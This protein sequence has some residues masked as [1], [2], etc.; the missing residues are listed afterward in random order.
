MMKNIAHKPSN[1]SGNFAEQIIASMPGGV[2]VIDMN[3]TICA[4]NGAMK[5]MLGHH[6]GD[7]GNKINH[8]VNHE[9]TIAGMIPNRLLRESIERGLAQPDYRH[10]LIISVPAAASSVHYL[11][12]TLA[13][14][15]LQ[16][17]DALLLTV[18]DISVSMQTNIQLYESEERFRVAFG[19][20]AVGLAHVTH[21]GRWLRV[22][23]KLQ[24][25]V[26]YSEQELSCLSFHDLTPAEDRPIDE[27]ALRR[28]FKGE[29]QNY[30]RE[31]RYI[32]KGGHVV[33]TNLTLAPM[34]EGQS[35]KSF[36]AVIEDISQRKR[37]EQELLHLSNYDPLTGLSNRVLLLDR[38]SQAITYANRAG[39]FVAVLYIDLDRF[40]NINDSLGHEIGNSVIVEVARRL[41]AS[42]R[43]G[44]TVA[45]LG[46]D[47]FVVVLTDMARESEVALV[48]QKIVDALNLPMVLQEQELSPVGSIGISIYPKD[49][50]DNQTLIKNADA[51]M[52]RAKQAGRSNFQFYAQDMNARSL[53]RLKLES[54]LRHALERGEFVLYY[55]PQM[56]IASCSI[57]GVEALI[58]WQPPGKAMVMPADFIP[59]AEETGLIVPMGEWALRTAC[60]QHVVWK[61]E[62]YP[63]VRM[64]VNLSARQFKQPGLAHMIAQILEETG[65]AATYLELEITESAI[66]DEPE[67][68]TTTL[69][70][71]SSMGIH[72]S[73]DD[74]GTGYSS[75]SYLK[76]FPIDTLKIDQSFVRDILTDADDAAIVKTII[77]L[78][79]SLKLKV[80]AEGVE[81]MEQLIFLREQQCDQM[82]GY[83]LSKPMPSAPLEKLLDW[84]YQV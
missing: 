60:A 49:G 72:L 66:M 74:F 9:M 6:P 62:G 59:I 18:D 81:T 24:E 67:E 65:C 45:R 46:G 71:L 26:G 58:R 63:E 3:R 1:T 16:G 76:R 5:K 42:I 73:I 22:N 14:T 53:D 56:E 39:R 17:C 77:V 78:A 48:A 44:D 25:I 38:L 19:Q 43:D 79:H 75:L 64:A 27:D 37:F 8:A 82:Q 80:I 36:I 30:S 55:Q 70:K 35:G 15:V 47:E 34:E 10:N 57:I 21:D 83:Y 28:L 2:M 29:M 69:R 7:L 4:V 50:T 52:S 31:K 61:E 84:R 11:R 13:R 51:A 33:W 41:S 54:G 68:A 32:H 20:A 40:K 12:C 23:R